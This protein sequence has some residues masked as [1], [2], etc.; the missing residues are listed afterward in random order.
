MNKIFID[1]Q[2]GTTGLQISERLAAHTNIE[3]LQADPATRKDP[4][5]R[6]DLLA[7]ADV[8]ILCL[9]DAA[10]KESVTLAAGNTR[11]LDASSAF[12]TNTAWQ[13]GLPELT[14]HS[15]QA[16]A[17]AQ[18]V[19]NPGCYPQ[20][21]LLLVRPLI[22]AGLLRPLYTAEMQCCLRLFR[23]WASNDRTISSHGQRHG[24][25]PCRAKLRIGSKP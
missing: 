19:S 22:D 15:R 24:Q 13:Y 25:Y 16:I 20:G 1:G 23:W 2:A 5:A 11:I 21:F 14:A 18:F 3:V 6:A 4:A 17:N 7:S 12:R 9:P 8:A 10:A